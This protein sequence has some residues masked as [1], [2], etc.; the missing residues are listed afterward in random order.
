VIIIKG[1]FNCFFMKAGIVAPQ[2]CVKKIIK[3]FID[4]I[5]P[6]YVIPLFLR[7]F[8]FIKYLLL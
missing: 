3:Y 5:I 4:V 8:I 1:N 6:K 7:E 2:I